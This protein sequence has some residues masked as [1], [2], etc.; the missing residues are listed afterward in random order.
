M[1]TEEVNEPGGPSSRSGLRVRD[2][3]TQLL[4]LPLLVSILIPVSVALGSCGTPGHDP[5]ARVP[6]RAGF[7]QEPP[8]AFMDSEGRVTGKAPE[9]LRLAVAELGLPE[10]EWVPMA[11]DELIPALVSGR[12][13]IL[14]AG[15]FVTPEREARVRFT[16]PTACVYPAYLVRREDERRHPDPAS[17]LDDG[18]SR[19]G[20]L[21]G[22]VE[23]AMLRDRGRTDGGVRRFHDVRTAALALEAGGVDVLLLTD[24]SARFLADQSEG[25]ALAVLEPHSEAHGAPPQGCSAFALRMQDQELAGRLDGAILRIRSAPDHDAVLERFGFDPGRLAGGGP[26]MGGGP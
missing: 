23:E 24:P 26:L 7:S 5:E 16:R 2:S 17:F 20:V 11:W 9:L 4:P 21:A 25:A 3:W 15:H 18:T 19:L 10:V 6:L 14:A 8:W 13:D 12:V 1:K 22:S